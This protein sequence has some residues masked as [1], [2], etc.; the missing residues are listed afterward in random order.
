M[1]LKTSAKLY[2][3]MIF[4]WLVLLALSFKDFYYSFRRV[5]NNYVLF[6]LLV[7]NTLFICYFWL[8]GMKE[9]FYVFFYWKNKN[10]IIKIPRK[11][12][13]DNPKVILLYCTCN[14]FNADSLAKS[15]K[16]KYSNFETYILDDS[17]DKEYIKTVN[18]FAKENN[19]KVIRRK[20]RI[21]FKAGNINHFLKGKEDY[22]YFVIL[23]SDEVIPKDFITKALKYFYSYKNIG[24]LQANHIS[25]RNVN[26]L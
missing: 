19:V 8:N 22:D 13:T 25:S 21:G 14:D 2:V 17:K 7:M 1:K 12:I 4:A 16:Q 20:D 5:G 10:K 9:I 3:Y 24:I 15:M 6:I 23:D 18:A 26:F 11:K